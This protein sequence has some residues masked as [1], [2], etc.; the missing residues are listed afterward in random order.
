MD[1]YELIEIYRNHIP[2]ISLAENIMIFLRNLKKR[3]KLGIV[4]DGYVVVQE[5]KVLALGLDRFMDAIVYTGN[6][7]SKPSVEPLLEIAKKLDVNPTDC[8][9]IGDNPL[10]DFGG[11]REAGFKTIRVLTGPYKDIKVEKD[12]D[13]V[14]GSILDIKFS[15]L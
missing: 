12:A 15:F 3:F 5:N 11:A 14:V 8:T 1:A 6:G 13:L 4:T 10:K 7:K 2:D 9:Y